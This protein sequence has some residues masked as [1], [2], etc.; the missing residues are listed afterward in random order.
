MSFVKP[1][2]FVF[3]FLL[4]GSSIFCCSCKSLAK[5]NYGVNRSGG[6]EP[7]VDPAR[8]KSSPRKSTSTPKSKK[9][10]ITASVGKEQKT[11][12]HTR[13]ELVEKKI[14]TEEELP[15]LDPVSVP[16][17][18]DEATLM[19][20]VPDVQKAGEKAIPGVDELIPLEGPIKIR[21]DNVNRIIDAGGHDV[22]IA[23]NNGVV[24]ITG[25]CGRLTVDGAGNQIQ[26]DSVGRIEV[27]GNENTLILGSVGGGAIK[28]DRNVLSWG[29]GIDGLSPIVESFGSDNSMKRL[30]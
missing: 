28:G 6:K 20:D 5:A 2:F 8:R 3:L 10:P 19:E 21:G 4:A 29:S 7:V 11:D 16:E 26:C 1:G 23:G 14:E 30:E 18:D 27:A 9:Q 15:A 12:S 24:V 25:G 22:Q 13:Q 17:I